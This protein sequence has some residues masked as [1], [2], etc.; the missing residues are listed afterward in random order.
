[1]NFLL[2][3]CAIITIGIIVVL[4]AATHKLIKDHKELHSV[5]TDEDLDLPKTL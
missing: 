4:Y 3:I 2:S 1:M 5:D